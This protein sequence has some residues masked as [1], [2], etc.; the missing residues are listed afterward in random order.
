MEIEKFEQATKV[1]DKLDTLERQKHKLESA[2]KSCSV[3]VTIKFTHTGAFPRKDEVSVY[4]KE[5]IKE[6][7]SKEIERLSLEIGLVKEEFENI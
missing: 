6:L 7:V 1:K 5:F 4:T 2:L 3:G